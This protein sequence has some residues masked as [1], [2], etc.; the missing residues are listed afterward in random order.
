M[1]NKKQLKHVGCITTTYRINLQNQ[2]ENVKFLLKF[3]T[4]FFCIIFT[5]LP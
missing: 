4:S 5:S 1:V 3:N 2:I